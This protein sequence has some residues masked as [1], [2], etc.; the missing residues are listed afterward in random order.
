MTSEQ[1]ILSFEKKLE[2]RNFVLDDKLLEQLLNG[3]MKRLRMQIEY[4]QEQRR[5]TKRR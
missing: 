5:S 1:E 4:N 3:K 2:E